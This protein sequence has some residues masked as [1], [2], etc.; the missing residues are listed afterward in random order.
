M[1]TKLS[2]TYSFNEGIPPHFLEIALSGAIKPS[3]DVH[4]RNMADLVRQIFP[5][6]NDT[7]DTLLKSLENYLQEVLNQKI[8]S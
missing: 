6:Q 1:L 5:D 4:I 2:T 7:D 8:E 3:E